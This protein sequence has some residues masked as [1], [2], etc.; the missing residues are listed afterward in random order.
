MSI[1]YIFLLVGIGII[2]DRFVIWDK[3]RAVTE[4][5]RYHVGTIG[6]L[7]NRLQKSNMERFAAERSRGHDVDP[8]E[9]VYT[10][11]NFEKEFLG[12][13]HSKTHIVRVTSM[14][15]SARRPQINRR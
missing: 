11:P 14:R 3:Q 15:R 13:G 8:D 6:D 4:E 10:N 9:Y 12:T 5:R 7:Q 1:F 2:I